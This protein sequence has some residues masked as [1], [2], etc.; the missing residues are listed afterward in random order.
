MQLYRVVRAKL[1]LVSMISFARCPGKCNFIIFNED[2]DDAY[3]R[4]TA[5]TDFSDRKLLN[6][7]TYQES[8]P[9]PRLRA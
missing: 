6:G 8:A 9:Q 4:S 1:G 2:W 5:S 3:H 7:G